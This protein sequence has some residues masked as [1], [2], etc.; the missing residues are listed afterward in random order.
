MAA[1]EGRQRLDTTQALRLVVRWDRMVRLRHA[2]GKP[3]CNVVDHI[4]RYERD[5]AVCPCGNTNTTSRSPSAARD[6]D[7]AQCRRCK[8]REASRSS[9]DPDDEVKAYRQGVRDGKED[10][11]QGEASDILAAWYAH[12]F[13]HGDLRAYAKGYIKGSKMN[14]RQREFEWH[15]VL[16]AINRGPRRSQWGI[17]KTPGR[18]PSRRLRRG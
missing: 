2:Q 14:P 4:L 11:R 16:M 8:Q 15:R 17:V 12:K 7:R 6:K 3:P 1:R 10:A 13:I 9:R 18:D 5:G